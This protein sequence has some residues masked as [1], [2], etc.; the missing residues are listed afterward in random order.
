MSLDVKLTTAMPA[1]AGALKVTV[2]VD[3]TPPCTVAGLMLTPLSGPGWVRTIVP[4]FGTAS[5]YTTWLAPSTVETTIGE[6][7]P[8]VTLTFSQ[9]AGTTLR[10][11][12]GSQ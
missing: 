9:A 6:E 12:S 3:E 8:C 2:P 11:V 5:W 4:P 7:L 1:G 10:I